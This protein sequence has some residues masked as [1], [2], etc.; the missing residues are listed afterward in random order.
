MLVPKI[1]F[2]LQTYHYHSDLSIHNTQYGFP[3]C[4]F[5]RKSNPILIKHLVQINFSAYIST[6]TY[7]KIVGYI[8][9]TDSEHSSVNFV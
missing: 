4:K 5:M 6:N 1:N 8:N 2:Y 9:V 3:L 7:L